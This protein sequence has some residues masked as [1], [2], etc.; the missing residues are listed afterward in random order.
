MHL[1]ATIHI[2][3]YTG[4]NDETVQFCWLAVTAEF[5][6]KDR[7]VHDLLLHKIELFLTIQG[8]PKASAWMGKY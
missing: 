2:N 4:G 6:I 7:E 1:L 3:T 5:D 8:H